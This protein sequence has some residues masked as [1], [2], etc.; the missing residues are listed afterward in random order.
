MQYKD[1]IEKMTLEEKCALVSGRDVWHT[2][3]ID[4]LGVPAI[5]LADGPS[6]LRRQ[7]AQGDHLGLNESVKATCFPSAATVANSWDVNLA[8][9]VG[10]AIGKEAREQGVD[11]VLGPGLNT[12]RSPLC[13]RNFE[14]F[15]EDPY[16]S[17]KLAA[18]FIQ[19]IQS[20]GVA[21]CPKHFAA[22]SQELRR[23]A[24]NSV[25]DMRTLQELY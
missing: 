21:A 5:S 15:S 16:L 4:R 14:Y 10:Q 18:G 23:M 11:V 12:K 20:Q 22:N 17:G 19:G 7:A 9:Q 8:Q 2:W 3:N 13:G 1:Y 6:G 25:V 24:N